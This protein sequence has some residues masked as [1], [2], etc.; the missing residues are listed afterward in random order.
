VA[1]HD[2]DFQTDPVAF[3]VSEL[4]EGLYGDV[5]GSLD[6]SI[7]Q[8]R[9]R[10]VRLG[11][12][13]ERNIRRSPLPGKHTPFASRDSMSKYQEDVELRYLLG[14]LEQPKRPHA[15]ATRK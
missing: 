10:G 2:A 8:Q 9:Q 15:S 14:L 13:E 3:D 4:W 12:N 6:G 1:V 11:G 7:D 5:D